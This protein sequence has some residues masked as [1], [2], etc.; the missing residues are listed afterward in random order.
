MEQVWRFIS[1]LAFYLLFLLTCP[2]A[3]LLG[4]IAVPV[5]EEAEAEP[6]GEDAGE[7]ETAAQRA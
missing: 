6:E 4:H 3:F 1:L 7:E 5:V 2:I